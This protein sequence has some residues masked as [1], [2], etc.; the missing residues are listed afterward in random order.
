MADSS[1]DTIVLHLSQLCIFIAITQ[2][3]DSLLGS[4][5]EVCVIWLLFI[6]DIQAS[7]D[8]APAIWLLVR[9][10]HICESHG[11]F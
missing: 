7:R 4:R 11:P 8:V 9:F 10:K 6:D 1:I 5:W 3:C 2:K